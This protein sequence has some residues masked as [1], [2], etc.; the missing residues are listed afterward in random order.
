M[1]VVAAQL[2]GPEHSDDRL[3]VTDHAVVM[4]DGASAFVPVPVPAFV[5]AET[6]GRYVCDGLD[7][8]PGRELP[9]LLS[10][11]IHHTARDLS[12]TPGKSPSSTI[13][14]VREIGDRIDILVLGD[15]LVVLPDQRII[16]DRLGR[17]DI[18]PR[19]RYRERLAAGS[20]YNDEHRALLTD[21]QTQ[22]ALRRNR[23][24]GYWIA[25]ADPE[26]AFH[27]ITTTLPRATTPWA[28]LATDGAYKTMRYLGLGQW[29]ALAI[30]GEDALNAL[31]QRC[32]TWEAQTDPSGQR[33]PR[34]K[35]HDDKTLALLAWH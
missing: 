24:D 31:L 34:A 9:E 14:I 35:Q 7:G 22:Q 28:V 10:A 27:A 26:A 5:H 1:K 21:L 23:P 12:L 20:G 17:L 3:F 33:F 2:P 4:L 8:N 13:T 25:E 18:A 16:D 29:N 15:N 6:L 11:A 32:R 30:G 19:R